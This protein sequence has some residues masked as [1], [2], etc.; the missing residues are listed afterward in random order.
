MT[1]HKLGVA[2]NDFTIGNILVDSMEN[3]T[4]VNVIDFELT[5][6]HTCSF[7]MKFHAFT[8]TTD[9]RRCREL[10]DIANGLKLVTPCA[11]IMAP[12][13]RDRS[14]PGV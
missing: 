9:F 14:Q 11:Y 12:V 5:K 6:P 3:P 13:L 1:L 10:Q 4:R 8:L 2:H 7:R